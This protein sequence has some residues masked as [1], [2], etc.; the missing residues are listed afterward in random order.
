L[1]DG[2]TPEFIGIEDG[3]AY[4]AE[5]VA[6]VSSFSN[7][8]VV[9]NGEKV[10]VSDDKTFSLAGLEGEVSL[11]ATNEVGT[12]GSIDILVSEAGRTLDAS[13]GDT[14]DVDE[15]SHSL[16]YV[17][18]GN[19]LMAICSGCGS[20]YK[21]S[22]GLADGTTKS[23]LKYT[24]KKITPCTVTYGS[25]WRKNVG[26]TLEIKYVNNIEPGTATARIT[27][28]DATAEYQFTIT[29]DS[30][31]ATGSGTDTTTGTS[32]TS[33][34]NATNLGQN[35]AAGTTSTIETAAVDKTGVNTASTAKTGAANS[36]AANSATTSK[37]ASSNTAD[38]NNMLPWIILLLASVSGIG[39][40]FGRRR[41]QNR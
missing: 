34:G 6:G 18:D 4:T 33:A 20:V 16:T 7:V 12:E 2:T 27:L 31:P 38:E 28:G 29:K 24:G 19:T 1:L 21:A 8:E 25:G 36:T 9:A 23:S 14:A 37:N 13:A 26:E 39:A 32:T 11:I 30:L 10:D 41:E 40:T 5:T 3:K 17:A 35:S 15:T 22:L